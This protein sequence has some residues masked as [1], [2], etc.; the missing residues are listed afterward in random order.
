MPVE[1]PAQA[2]VGLLG[3]DPRAWLWSAGEPA[4][5]SLMLRTGLALGNPSAVHHLV[6]DDPQV[7]SL[8][9]LLPDWEQVPTR[10][11]NRPDFAPNLLMLLAEMGLQAGDNPRIEHLLDQMLAHQEPDGRFMSYG[12][13]F[14]ETVP[15]WGSMLCDHHA[16]LEALL[17]YG[18]VSDPKVQ[19]GLERMRADLV[20]T[21]QG[22][23]WPCVPHSVSGWRGPGRKGD[24]CPQVTLEALR[25][26]AYLPADQWPEHLL[27]AAGTSLAAWR[28]RG[29]E[30]P[31]LFGHGRQFKTVK[32]PTTWY[33]AAAVLN[34][35]SAYPSLREQPESRRSLA[36]LLACLISYNFG[37]DG[38][39]TPRSCYQGFEAFSFGQKKAPSA[40]ATARLCAILHTYDDLEEDV[41]LVDV[42]Q[43]A[44]SRGGTG[45]A[46]P[47]K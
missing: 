16:I 30:K 33:D 29:T 9:N 15:V 12:I 24:C 14:K 10:G 43:L 28:N 6:A 44:S 35:L 36:E 42:R 8:L 46:L 27:D 11:H 32:W 18:R 23:G 17:H 40:W 19:L 22:Y 2:W 45:V 39:V 21:A 34:S 47:P 3:G 20:L 25:V 13:A 41:K 38:T 31:Y 4:V 7:R 1:F 37:V 26:F 5:V